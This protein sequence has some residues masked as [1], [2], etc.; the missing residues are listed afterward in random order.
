[1]GIFENVNWKLTVLRRGI[2]QR[3]LW[4]S[5]G[6]IPDFPVEKIVTIDGKPS[7]IGLIRA[8]MRVEAPGVNPVEFSVDGFIFSRL[9]YLT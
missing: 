7:G 8:T 2:I 3:E 4:Q 9:V 5:S 1:M 6:T